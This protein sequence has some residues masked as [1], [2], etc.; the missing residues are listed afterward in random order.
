[1]HVRIVIARVFGSQ[2]RLVNGISGM[3]SNND[4]S[5]ILISLKSFFYLQ[6]LG[7]NFGCSYQH[8]LAVCQTFLEKPIGFLHRSGAKLKIKG[9]YCHLFE[10]A[11]ILWQV[12]EAV[13]KIFK[14]L[15]FR[16]Q[17]I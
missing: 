10:W 13:H 7:W 5:L 14:E 9:I 4:V 6:W 3:K 1:M 2:L 16:Y 12:V 11:L 17:G 8:L 15:F